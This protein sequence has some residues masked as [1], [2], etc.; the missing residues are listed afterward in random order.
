LLHAKKLLPTATV[1]NRRQCTTQ[2]LKLLWTDTDSV[3]LHSFIVFLALLSWLYNLAFL[4]TIS[5][6][7]TYLL[8]TSWWTHTLT[9]TSSHVS[10]SPWVRVRS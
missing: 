1:R 9:H 4:A 6:K 3:I 8:M 5:N 10:L 7:L 2:S